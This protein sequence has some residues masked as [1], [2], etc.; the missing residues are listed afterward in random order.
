MKSRVLEVC[1]YSAESVHIS[2]QCGAH[3]VELCSNRKEGGTTPSYGAVVEAMK[4][5]IPVCPILRPRGGD[6]LYTDQEFEEMLRDAELF[7]S[8]QTKGIVFGIL[9]SNGT[10]DLTRMQHIMDCTKNQEIVVHRAFDMCNDPFRTLE[11]L[12]DLGVHR[13]LTSGGKNTAIEG[14]SLL[15]QL[16]EKAKGRVTIMAGSGIKSENIASLRNI[17]ITEFHASA[18][19]FLPSEMEF[20]N[21]SIG[22]GLKSDPDEFR[23]Q[24]CDPLEIKNLLAAIQE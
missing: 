21:E 7:A 23:I 22:M 24:Q 1:C 2:A 14:I 18:T 20:R 5:T 19:R 15:E 3:R 13:I 12:I 17:G 11:E 9:K 16:T 10:F 4:S 8:L 6:F